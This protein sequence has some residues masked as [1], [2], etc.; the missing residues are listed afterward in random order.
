MFQKPSSP[1]NGGETLIKLN[2]N[3]G[4]TKSIWKAVCFR[5]SVLGYWN[6]LWVTNFTLALLP[7]IFYNQL[8]WA[9]RSYFIE[10]DVLPNLRLTVIRVPKTRH[11]YFHSNI[12][13]LDLWPEKLLLKKRKFGELRAFWT[14]P[15]WF[16]HLLL[17]LLWE[18]VISAYTELSLGIKEESANLQPRSTR[19]SGNFPFQKSWFWCQF[20]FPW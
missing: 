17:Q 19:F 1:V 11:F 16:T 13:S 5:L 7:N 9:L 2:K 18:W 4:S 3:C 8:G 14:I 10:R 12:S 20:S 6:Q 15:S